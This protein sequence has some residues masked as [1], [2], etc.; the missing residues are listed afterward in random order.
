MC[1]KQQ[2]SEK[3]RGNYLLRQVES[4]DQS[5]ERQELSGS[6]LTEAAIREPSPSRKPKGWQDRASSW[7]QGG[8]NALSGR[9]SKRNSEEED[10]DDDYDDFDDDDPHFD[11]LDDIMDHDLEST[12]EDLGAVGEE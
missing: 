7:R 6:P 10:E 4:S 1:L 8:R 9:R 5:S 2:G 11:L 12:E 3:T